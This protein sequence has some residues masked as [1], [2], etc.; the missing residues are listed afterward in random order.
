MG[1]TTQTAAA[2]LVCFNDGCRA[3]YAITQVLYNCPK[4][5]GLMEAAYGATQQPE[6]LK[7]IF[8][9]RRLNNNPLDQ[10]GVWRDR[11]MVSFLGGLSEN[12]TMRQGRNPLLEWPI[13]AAH[14]G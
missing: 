12:G 14:C 4:C 7:K 10:S 2:E 11:E 5:G 6:T 13:A 1:S 9:E 8:R 3:R